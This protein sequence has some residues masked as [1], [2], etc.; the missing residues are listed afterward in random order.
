MT[1]IPR[2]SVAAW[3]VAVA[4]SLMS[5]PAFAQT[6]GQG[7]STDVPWLRMLLALGLCLALAAGAAWA[8]RTR[9]SGQPPRPAAVVN[10]WIAQLRLRLPVGQTASSTG[11]LRIVQSIGLPQQGSATLLAC[12]GRQYLVV[13]NLQ[14]RLEVI[15]TAPA[16]GGDDDGQ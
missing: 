13:S 9:L 15:E 4:A 10:S 6:L 11:P 12:G 14:G 8:V 5:G 3:P 2:L 7:P 16:S 1:G